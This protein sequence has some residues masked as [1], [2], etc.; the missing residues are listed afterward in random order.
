[1]MTM[2]ENVDEEDIES[3]YVTNGSYAQGIPTLN[4]GIL[5]QSEQPNPTIV[6]Q[7]HAGSKSAVNNETL[8]SQSMQL[9]D[10]EEGDQNAVVGAHETSISYLTK[11][12][13][14][15]NN[16]QNSTK[17]FSSKVTASQDK[18]PTESTMNQVRSQLDQFTMASGRLKQQPILSLR[19]GPL[20]QSKLNTERNQAKDGLLSS[21]DIDA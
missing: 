16:Q 21:L 12:Q 9:S 19:R 1:M 15:G 10:D 6:T 11:D 13:P 5:C 20:Q 18:K 4:R 7:A 17:K 3:N 14:Q 8:I 2:I